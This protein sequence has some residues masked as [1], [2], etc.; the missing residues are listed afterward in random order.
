MTSRD[1][2]FLSA[3]AS[4]EN[5]AAVAS[6][7]ADR[8]QD[9][10]VPSDALAFLYVSEPLADDLGS[11][12]T[13]LRSCLGLEHWVG[14]SGVGVCGSGR[15]Y[16]GVPAASVLIAPMGRDRFHIFEPLQSEDDIDAPEMRAA[17]ARLQ[18]IFGLV[19]CDPGAVGALKTLPELARIGSTYLVGGVAS[20]ERVAPQIADKVVDGGLSGVLFASDVAV[21]VGLSQACT[22]IGPI[23]RI[24]EGR[25]GIISM[26]DDQPALE[27][28][29]DELERDGG[30]QAIATGR[31]HV[32][33]MIPGSD[34]GDFVVR[35]LMGVDPQNDLMAVSGE[36]CLGDTIRFVRRDAAA[37]E[38][39][40][41]RML[42]DV[43]RR[44]PG[45]PR[46]AIYCSCVARGPHLFGTENREM[47]IIR[48]ELG[49]LP[50][51]GFY[52]NGEVCN[53]R[54]YN[55]TG[56]LTLFV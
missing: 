20:G 10:P 12:L 38:Q 5:W 40:L 22:P 30:G 35:N 48:E 46:G 26:I 23:H 27:V 31:Y 32:A 41:R 52:G 44:L 29:R 17:I 1:T 36:F 8:L 6:E 24:T 34:T 37:A 2:E 28:F 16:F 7:L 55:Y 51:T 45:K 42:N 33:F 9:M 13:F 56:V 15:A 49:D 3:H 47:M 14:A 11:I 53:D 4:G 50:L 54:F 21:Q 25:G 19:H 39:D 18:P 43:Q